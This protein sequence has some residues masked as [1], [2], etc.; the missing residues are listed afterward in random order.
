MSYSLHLKSHIISHSV[1]EFKAICVDYK[2][3]ESECVDFT[4]DSSLQVWH[5]GAVSVKLRST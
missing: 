4:V 1:V 2:E 3:S 5:R